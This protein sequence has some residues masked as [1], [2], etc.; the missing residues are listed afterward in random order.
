M[1][2]GLQGRF[3]SAEII[4]LNISA[5][6][7]PQP[8]LISTIPFRLGFVTEHRGMEWEETFSGAF[9]KPLMKNNMEVTQ[10]FYVQEKQHLQTIAPM[11][12]TGQQPYF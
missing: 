9:Q 12:L 2:C 7:L 3:I 6:F 10:L 8:F 1:G 4:A 5:R 11:F